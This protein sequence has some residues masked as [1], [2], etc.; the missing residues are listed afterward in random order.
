M[1]TL[2]EWLAER[3]RKRC[4]RDFEIGFSWAAG[5]ILLKQETIYSVAHK[6]STAM[7][8]GTYTAFDEGVLV[9]VRLLKESDILDR[10]SANQN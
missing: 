6:C 9:A 7:T 1:R 4:R 2:K 8:F 5:Q 10:L 3:K